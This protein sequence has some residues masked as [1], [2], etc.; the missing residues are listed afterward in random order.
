MKRT[1]IILMLITIVSK[2]FGFARDLTLAYFYGATPITDAYIVSLSIP[3]V[4]FGLIAAAIATGYIPTYTKLESDIGKSEADLYTNNLI[5]LVIFLCTLLIAIGWIFTTPIVK[6]FASGFDGETLALAVR[7]TKIMLI[8]VYF[9]GL[10]AIFSAYL[11]IRGNY[12]VTA[13][14]GFPMNLIAILTFFLSA[15]TNIIIL[16]FGSVI[17]SA[18]QLLLLLVFLPQKGYKYRLLLNLKDKHIRSMSYIMIPVM[19][20]T[21]VNQLNVLVDKTMASQIAVGGISAINY[22]NNLNGFVIGIVVL[23][24]TTVM[25][26]IISKMSA[27]QNLIGLKKTITEAVGSIN[28]LVIPASIGAMIFAEPII[29]LLFGR[30]AFNESSINMTTAALF[31]YS[32]GMLG[33]A[34]RDVLARTFYALHDAKTPMINGIIS[35]ILNILLI[36]IL[37]RFMGI[38]GLALA[39]SIS[40]ITCTVLLFWN[41][42]RKIGPLGMRQIIISSFK[43]I[44]ASLAMGVV[45][46]LMFI[47][48]SFDLGPNISLIL[49]IF[50]G[51]NIYAVIIYFLKIEEADHIFKRIKHIFSINIS[52]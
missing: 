52:K 36:L 11:Q 51:M 49:A 18:S 7:F 30:G 19:I 13:M 27:E 16:A 3:S 37:S 29:R 38:G 33:Y 45:T 47:T 15:N 31:F 25:Y 35:A 42:R 43:I 21:S 17:A 44:G 46:K 23:S 22:A 8:G 39:T 10:T 41:L 24:I 9:T 6:V 4:L 26:P 34:L 48:L 40:A 32:V 5:N 1:A 28:L 20:G 14:I 12:I 50:T 2:V